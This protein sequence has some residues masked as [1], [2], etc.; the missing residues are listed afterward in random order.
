M[1][2]QGP[3]EDQACENANINKTVKDEYDFLMR[4]FA[5]KGNFRDEIFPPILT[6][7]FSF[8]SKKKKN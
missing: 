6:S 4:K 7:V 2:G 3:K 5:K 1:S 8:S